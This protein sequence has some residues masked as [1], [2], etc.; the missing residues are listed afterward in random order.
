MKCFVIH[1]SE[2]EHFGTFWF[3]FF[4][5]HFVF[6]VWNFLFYLK[7]ESEIFHF[8]GF[9]FNILSLMSDDNKLCSVQ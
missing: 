9:D 7:T 4:G 2:S 1:L 8:S 5:L 3:K 6:G